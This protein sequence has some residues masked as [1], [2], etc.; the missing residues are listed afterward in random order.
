MIKKISW[1]LSLLICATLVL[2]ACTPAAPAT[3]APAAAPTTAPASAGQV[4]ISYAIWDNNQLPAHQ[5]IIAAFEAKNPNIKVTVEVV[6]WEAYWN[7]LQTAVAGGEAY[8]TFW[9]NGPNFPVYAAKGVLMDLQDRVAKDNVDMSKYSQSLVKLY[10]YNEHVYGLPKDFDTIG[11]YYNKDLFDK[12][13]VAYPTADWTWDDL[14]AAAKKLSDPAKGVWG[15]AVPGDQTGYWNFVYQNGGEILAPDGNSVKVDQPAACEAITFLYNTMKAG[16]MPD[17]ATTTSMD[18][19]TQLFPGGK[20]AMITSGSWSAKTFKA[21][22]FKL[23]VAPLPKKVKQASIIHGLAN[24]VWSGTKHPE[25]AWAFVKFLGSEEAANILA[26][27]GTV[28]PAYQGMQDKWLKSMPDLD[29]KVF[30]DALSYSVPYPNTPKGTEWN[31]KMI[32]AKDDIWLGN[33]PIDQGCK[34]MATAANTVLS[35]P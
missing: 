7:K 30:I 23:G 31:D 11:L 26:E 9:M 21:A 32:A 4:T 18:P 13:G 15:L 5:Q 19:E 27:S 2:G 16:S 6:P 29:L 1:I 14:A 12:A 8:D 33:T 20:I 25:E 17:A 34:A 35:Q 10:S 3:N 28:I 24:V 22:G